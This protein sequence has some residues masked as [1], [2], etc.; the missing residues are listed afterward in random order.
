[1]KKKY[2]AVK[3]GKQT[4]IYETWDDCK[5]QINGYKNAKYKSFVNK[6]DALDY[7]N[8]DSAKDKSLSMPECYAFIDGSFNQN[9]NV[10]G[11]GGFLVVNDKKII[12]QGHNNI[13]EMAAMRNVAGE[14][15]GSIN[16][17]KKAIDLGLKELTIYYDYLGIE[18]WVTGRWTANKNATKLYSKTMNEF[19]QKID[20]KFVK[21]KGHSGIEGNEIA[22]KLA[23]ES[24]RIL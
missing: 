16:A 15:C 6:T 7:L 5:E 3:I 20:I 4:G 18:F 17:V 10:Y 8:N 23:K 21:V 13:P 14:I 22:D 19:K 2:Y 11:Y 24:V 12:I 9:T 1:M